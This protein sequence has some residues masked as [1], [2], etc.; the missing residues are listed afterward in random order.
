M[1]TYDQSYFDRWY[2]DPRDRVATDESLE[3]KVR[4]AVSTAEFLTGRRIRTVLDVGCGEAPWYP[5]LR[6][7]RRDVRYQGVD[8]SDYVLRRF[9]RRRHIRRGTF[10]ELRE[11][12]LG[13]KFDLIVCAD[14]L[15]YVSERDV[16]VGLAEIKRLLGGVAYIEA[17]TAEDHMEGDHAGW[18]E[19]PATAYRR[20]FN[21]AGL[22]QC[23][24]NCWL[25][26]ERFENLNVFETAG[27]IVD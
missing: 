11:L 16:A 1:K 26:L 9:G 18:H 20:L 10:G 5:V 27:R 23:G 21:R 17:F 25:D 8:S 13:R 12:R 19:R 6:K 2:R 7:L 3:R 14:V 4:L 24:P 15:Q 22:T